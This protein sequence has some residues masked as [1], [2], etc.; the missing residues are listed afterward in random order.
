MRSK[1]VPLLLQSLEKTGDRYIS[2]D[3]QNEILAIM[4][5]RL[6]VVCRYTGCYFAIICYDYTDVSNKEQLTFCIR[7]ADNEMEHVDF[8]GLTSSVIVSYDTAT[9]FRSSVL[10]RC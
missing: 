2:H 9:I 7:W 1:D 4:A 6:W 10:R 3:I 5:E 8:L